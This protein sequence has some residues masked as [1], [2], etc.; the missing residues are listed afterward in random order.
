MSTFIEDYIGTQ[1]IS[2]F[3]DPILMGIVYIGFFFGIA[4]FGRMTV[5]VGT[6]ILVG[7]TLVSF[8]FMPQF[9]IP[10]A[11]ITGLMVAYG[12]YRFYK[13]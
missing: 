1:S 2:I 5:V 8:E 3:G 12:L 4:I 13:G 10:F 7:A 6:P 9:K 11:I